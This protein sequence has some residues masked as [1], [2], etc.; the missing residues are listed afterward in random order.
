MLDKLRKKLSKDNTGSEREL[1]KREDKIYEDKFYQEG[2]K[3]TYSDLNTDAQR[4][5]GQ[6]YVDRYRALESEMETRITEWNNI[7]KQYACEREYIDDA[8]N[9]FIPVT[10]PIIDGMIASVVDQNIAAKV[11][12][13]T[14]SDQNFAGS[15]QKIVDLFL[16]HNKTKQQ[17]KSIAGR[18]FKFGVGWI[19]IEWDPNALDGFGMPIIRNPQTTKIFIDGNIKDT[20]DYQK[21]QYLIEEVGYQSIMWGRQEYGDDVANY[22]MLNTGDDDFEA[23]PLDDEQFS[24]MLLK[25]WHRNNKWG[26]LQLLEM[27]DTGFV[28]RESDPESPY[29]DNVDNQ[30]P[31][32]PIGLYQ[33]EGEFYRFGDGKRLFFIQ[34]TINKL[35]DEIITACKFTSQSRT[36]VDPDGEM[37][38]DDFDND[39]SHPVPCRNPR[40]NVFVSSGGSLNPIIERLLANLMNEARRAARFSDLMMSNSPSEKM[41]ATQAGIQTSQGNVGISDKKGDISEG[42]KFITNYAIN[43]CIE[44]WTGGQWY[45]V[46]EDSDDFEWIDA[47]QL[48]KVPVL[49]PRNDE[50]IQK[51]RERHPNSDISLMPQYTQYIPDADIYDYEGEIIAR[52]GEPQ[53]KR[54]AFDLS[55]SIGEGLPSSPIALFNIMLS[56]AQL[57]LIDEQTGQSRPLIGYEQFRKLM[58]E[59]IG[60]P[61]DEAMEQAKELQTQGIVKPAMMGSNAS[62]ASGV[63]RP[64][65]MSGN[66]P[67]ANINDKF[68]G[69]GT[70]PA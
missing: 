39:P 34:D 65:N 57:S 44:L 21:A 5:R 68:K 32:Y 29:Y 47:A 20:L 36:F 19:A 54:V 17:I 56:L 26:N 42:M 46:T 48:K 3:K 12:G 37:D 30:Y 4:K 55:V 64:L 63:V 69:A 1:S 67:G 62:N 16:R 51:W 24:F 14:P 9:S 35:Y 27:D 45:R 52:K 53:T 38:P 61:F 40:E 13:I 50:F 41:T 23:A 25:V 2:T 43:M 22:L 8:P 60:I 59:T 6:F 58:E 7:E 33:K 66:I 49:I 31:Y 15:G 11:K 18:Y 10:G 28:L 70:V